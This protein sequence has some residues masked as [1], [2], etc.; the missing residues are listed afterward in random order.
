M[1]SLLS[2]PCLALFPCTVCEVLLSFYHICLSWNSLSLYSMYI[3]HQCHKDKCLYFDCIWQNKVFCEVANMFLWS[4]LTS[5]LGHD[6]PHRPAPGEGVA[7]GTVC[8]D[9]MVWQVN[10]SLNPHSTSLL[11]GGK[12]NCLSHLWP[13][14]WSDHSSQFIK[15]YVFI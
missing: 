2:H 1:C 4:E 7:V 10:A 15:M 6:L 11:W 8:R 9:Q 5:E 3:L 12:T 14:I 13:L